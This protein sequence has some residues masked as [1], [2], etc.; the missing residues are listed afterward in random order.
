MNFLGYELCKYKNVVIGKKI[1]KW[2]RSN[3]KSARVSISIIR[4]SGSVSES[5]ENCQFHDNVKIRA[6]WASGL[7]KNHIHSAIRV[8]RRN[9]FRF[10]AQL[11]EFHRP[12][13]TTRKWACNFIN[14]GVKQRNVLS[15]CRIKWFRSV[16]NLLWVGKLEWIYE[17]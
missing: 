14:S 11:N 1:F 5:A 13:S 10:I 2:N 17:M 7:Q 4:W 6:S 15:I 3:Y 16:W 8:P 12:F 9:Y